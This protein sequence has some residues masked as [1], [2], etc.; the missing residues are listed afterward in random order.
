TGLRNSVP[1]L[2][3]GVIATFVIHRY[4]NVAKPPTWVYAAVPLILLAGLPIYSVTPLRLLVL[5]I[6]IPF[7]YLIV[8]FVI[9]RTN[10]DQKRV[11]V[12]LL[13]LAILPTLFLL[14]M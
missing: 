13:L 3:L 6:A 12:I 14:F 11:V 2:G 4:L 8:R 7:I 9:D 10:A 1:A 5:S